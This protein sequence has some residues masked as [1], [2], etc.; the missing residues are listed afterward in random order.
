MNARMLWARILVILGAVAMLIGAIDPLEGS[1]IIL[2]GSGMVTLGTFIGRSRHRILVYW[3]WVFGLI[4]VG[5]GLVWGISAFGGLGGST[6]RSLWWG[7]V[8]LP[9]PIGWIM[10]VGGLIA[11]L[12][13]FIKLRNLTLNKNDPL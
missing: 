7:L 11:R 4:A 13:E 9:Y 5:V 12:V 1:L 10:G 8:I 6:G 3:V 2:L